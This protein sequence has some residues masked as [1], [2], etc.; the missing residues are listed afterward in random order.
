[1]SSPGP[2]SS[3]NQEPANSDTDVC[4][5]PWAVGRLR[6]S[7]TIRPGCLRGDLCPVVHVEG[8]WSGVG[9]DGP[10]GGGSVDEAS[11]DEFGDTSISAVV[12]ADELYVCSDSGLAGAVVELWW[13]ADAR[14]SH[15]SSLVVVGLV[16]GVWLV[17]PAYW[18]QVVPG[19]AVA[20]VT[21]CLV[22]WVVVAVHTPPGVQWWISMGWL[23]RGLPVL[24]VRVAVRVVML[25]VRATRLGRVV[26]A[27]RRRVRSWIVIAYFAA[28]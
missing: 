25:L 2:G 9:V 24:V 27:T 5:G 13:A 4:R 12:P 14:F 21:P 8:R 26:V 17:L 6:G 16:V 3:D 1:M 20:E 15:S 22:V 23:V 28:A 19:V 10:V 7:R 18:N 11:F